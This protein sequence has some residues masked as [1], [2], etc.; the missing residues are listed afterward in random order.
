MCVLP[1]AQA[2]KHSVPVPM[3]S[4]ENVASLERLP[5]YATVDE[6]HRTVNANHQPDI[7]QT[8]S[9]IPCTS[10]HAYEL[11]HLGASLTINHPD[12][13]AALFFVGRYEKQ[14]VS[15]VII[16]RGADSKAPYVAQAKFTAFKKDFHLYVGGLQIPDKDDWDVVRCASEGRMFHSDFCRFEVQLPPDDTNYD[17]PPGSRYSRRKLAWKKTHDPRL[18]ASRLSIRDFK[19]VDEA[20]DEVVAVYLE[21]AMGGVMSKPQ[22]RIHLREKF[23]E[24]AELATLVSLMAILERMRRHMRQLSR[25]VPAQGV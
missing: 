20:S 10:A 5:S 24:D 14:N 4:E 13:Q 16:Y 19:L 9:N 1:L 12:S 25:A 11:H 2:Q 8:F 3:D 21:R 22:G 7:Q 23:N 17:R 18:G 6:Q 15:D